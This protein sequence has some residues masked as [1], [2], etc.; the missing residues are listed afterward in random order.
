MEKSKV[1][2]EFKTPTR[3]FAA[4]DLVGPADIDGALTFEERQELGHIE[5]PQPVAAKPTKSKD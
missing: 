1:L 3:K 2:V 4:G 5:K